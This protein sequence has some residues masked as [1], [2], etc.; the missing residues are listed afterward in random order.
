MGEKYPVDFGDYRLLRKFAQ[1]GMAEVFVATNKDGKVCAVKRILPHLAHQENFIR[2]F[3]DEARIVSNLTHPN[4]AGVTAHGKHDGYY[5]IEMEYVEGHSLLALYERAKSQKMALPL[6]LLAYIVSELLNGLGHAHAARDKKGRYLSIVHRDVTPQNVL[7]SYDGTVKLI[8]FGVAKARARLTH[9]DAGFTKGKLSY[10]SPEQARGDGLDGRSDLFSV[11]IILYELTTGR[12]LFNKEGPGGILGA[13]VNDPVTPPTY[14]DRQYPRDLEAIVMRALEKESDRRWQTAEEMSDALK[15]FARRERP[16]PGSERLQNLVYD[17]FGEPKNK[18]VIDEALSSRARKRA[19][20]RDSTVSGS[21][22]DVSKVNIAEDFAIAEPAET[23]MM[24]FSEVAKVDDTDER[25]QLIES[26]RAQTDEG[27]PELDLS[28]E[29][30]DISIPEPKIPWRVKLAQKLNSFSQDVAANY[31]AHPWR[32]RV[33]AAILAMA[34]LFLVAFIAGFFDKLGDAMDTAVREA[35]ELKA[36]AGLVGQDSDAGLRPTVLVIKSDP[37]GSEILIDTI[38]AGCTTP[39]ELDQLDQGKRLNVII[40]QA[41]YRDALETITLRKNEGAR[42]LEVVLEKK[43]AML[44]IQ[45]QPK[46]AFVF[47]DG[48]KQSS[49]TP[50]TL[51]AVPVDQP[52]EILVDKPGYLEAKQSVT[53]RDREKQSLRFTLKRDPRS[54]R[55]GKV[56]VRTVPPNCQITIGDRVIGQSPLLHVLKPGFHTVIADCKNF[57]TEMQTVKIRSKKTAEVML[58]PVPNVFGYLSLDISPS[59]GNVVRINGRKIKTPIRFRKVIPGRHEVEVSNSRLRRKKSMTVR[60]VAN[61]R[62]SRS[63]D[64]LK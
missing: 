29:A 22:K 8:D 10:M 33:G 3:I 38:G 56:S 25:S 41:G 64:L 55:P 36:S 20:S 1:G 46:S 50:I 18:S 48:K 58:Q 16:R 27:L 7:V 30:D 14:K 5:Y 54:I 62:V 49:K 57:E 19:K 40:R 31:Q 24:E 37:P 43:S 51:N 52:V 9:T 28:L 47:V 44:T 23:R 59:D 2:M 17:L 4:V 11:G 6:G 35:R 21:E 53:L 13:I 26:R 61:Q 34:G 12:R 39:C 32:Y 42:N 60:V 45:S 63:I 15:R